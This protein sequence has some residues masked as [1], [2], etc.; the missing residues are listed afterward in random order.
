M[1]PTNHP[2][3]PLG[4][5]RTGRLARLAAFLRHHAALTLTAD[6]RAGAA[7]HRRHLGP[8]PTQVIGTETVHIDQRGNESTIGAI[9]VFDEPVPPGSLPSLR[10]RRR[11]WRWSR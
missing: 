11:G 2:T 9:Y 10:P 3:P 6:G 7:R 8:A 4:G 1:P 5:A